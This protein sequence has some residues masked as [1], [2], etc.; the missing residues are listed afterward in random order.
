[1]SKR[2][3]C[4]SLIPW[5]AAYLPSI[6]NISPCSAKTS[7]DTTSPRIHSLSF[8][9]EIDSRGSPGVQS[10]Q[11]GPY[12]KGDREARR[13]SATV[14]KQRENILPKTRTSHSDKNLATHLEP[15]LRRSLVMNL[16]LTDK[17]LPVISRGK[18]CRVDQAEA[19]THQFTEKF[20]GLAA[21]DPPYF[22]KNG[23]RSVPTTCVHCIRIR[24]VGKFALLESP[25]DL[26]LWNCRANR[27]SA[28]ED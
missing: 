26:G 3:S 20:A 11:N 18:Q 12:R 4:Q 13:L 15:A 17:K 2:I 21:L 16:G 19:Q 24:Y 5:K 28:F 1:M 6:G 8:A 7:Q 9:F 10:G 22:F 27:E 14:N 25:D 23:T